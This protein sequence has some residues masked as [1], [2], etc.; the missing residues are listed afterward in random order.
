[1]PS[2]MRLEM[3]GEV[4]CAYLQGEIDHHTARIMREG[5]DL[6][7]EQNRPSLLLLDFSGVSF[8]DSSGVGLVMGRYREMGRLRGEVQI[9][10][11]SRQIAKLMSMAGLDRL[12]LLGSKSAAKRGK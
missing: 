8:M 12:N 10:G 5:I 11:A 2:P 6:A 9:T 3:K 4:L 1:M 7:L